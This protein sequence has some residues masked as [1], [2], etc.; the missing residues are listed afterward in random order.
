MLEKVRRD[1][2][3][4]GVDGLVERWIGAPAFPR[5]RTRRLAD[6]VRL[7]PAPTVAVLADGARVELAERLLAA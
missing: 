5:W 6:G 7:G 3:H 2:R 4:H 1:P